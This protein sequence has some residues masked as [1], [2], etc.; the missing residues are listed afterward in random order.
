V[1]AWRRLE[2]SNRTLLLLLGATS[3]FDGYD[4][5][6]IALALTQIR[7]TFHLSQGSASL[8]LTFLYLGSLP[9]LLITRRADAI[10]RRRVLLFCVAAYTIATGA[11]SLAPT[12]AVF[13]GLQFFARLFLHAESAIVWTIAAEEL[14]AEARGFGFGALGMASSLGV[15]FGAILYGGLLQPL[16]VSWRFMYVAALPPLVLVAALRRRLPETRR[17]IA[18]RDSG[19]LADRW[20]R[21]FKPEVRRALVLVLSTAFLFQLTAQAS[22]FA[23]DFLQTNRGLS[24]SAASFMLVGAG[25]PAIPLMVMAGSLSDRFGRRAIGCAFGLMSLAGAMCFFW[26]PGGVPVLLPSLT[27]VLVGQ[28]GS[29]PV[30]AGYATELFPT[31]L[32]GQA[33]AWSGVAK[34]MGSAT[35]LAL[36][37]VL[38]KVTGGL[39]PTTTIL[40]LGPLLAIVI[41][42]LRFPDTHGRELEETSALEHHDAS[43]DL[44]PLHLGEGLLHAVEPDPL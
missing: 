22:I 17:F 1:S 3:F 23:L 19:T 18:A 41:V 33:S 6:I 42:A 44:A 15:G 2:R 16:G 8:W 27:L 11:T 26:L 38:L 37:G 13:I 36:G 21:I 4:A 24:A 5:A 10:G 31:A 25:I 43:Q 20:H 40:A 7:T 12:M 32:R 34:V 9:A 29:F 14:P 28:L 35:S 39:S 30:I